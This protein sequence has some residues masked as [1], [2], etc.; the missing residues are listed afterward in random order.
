[1]CV[2]VA[3]T[4][5]ALATVR[6]ADRAADRNIVRLD[7]TVVTP[8][9]IDETVQLSRVAR[10]ADRRHLHSIEWEGYISYDRPRGF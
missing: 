7:G 9:A 1:M 6:A 8:A 3:V 5:A 4:V 10:A 2:S